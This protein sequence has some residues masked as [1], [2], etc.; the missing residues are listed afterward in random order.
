[1]SEIQAVFDM[2]HPGIALVHQMRQRGM[3]EHEIQAQLLNDEVELQQRVNGAYLGKHIPRIPTQ[4]EINKLRTLEVACVY[5]SIDDI[6]A[7]RALEKIAKIQTGINPYFGG[8]TMSA[9][10]QNRRDSYEATRKPIA[11]RH[12]TVISFRPR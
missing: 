3:F 8:S 9:E 12:G 5:S 10:W 7:P 11:K 4:D 2:N 6:Y 1:M